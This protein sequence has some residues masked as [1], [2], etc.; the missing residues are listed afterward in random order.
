MPQDEH[1]HGRT[2]S[3]GRTEAS[4]G[5]GHLVSWLWDGFAVYDVSELIGSCP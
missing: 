3:Q 4:R 1:T 2:H 5:H